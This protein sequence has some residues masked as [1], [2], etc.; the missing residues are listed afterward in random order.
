MEKSFDDLF[1]AVRYEF[2]QATRNG[3]LTPERESE[4][5]DILE[6]LDVELCELNYYHSQQIREYSNCR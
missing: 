5:R 2:K 1:S 3:K 4:I 6:K